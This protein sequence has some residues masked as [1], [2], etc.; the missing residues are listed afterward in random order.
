M[1]PG[2]NERG[3]ERWAVATASEIGP[4][5]RLLVEVKR[6]SIGLFNVNGTF[7]A[8]LNVCPHELAPVCRGRLGGTTLPSDPGIYRWGRDGEILTCPWHGWEFGLLDGRMLADP[9]IRLRLY[10]VEI[11]DDTVYIRL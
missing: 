2:G 10:P 8:A 3:T 9:R 1:S 5:D 11:E 6:H 7:V 4:G